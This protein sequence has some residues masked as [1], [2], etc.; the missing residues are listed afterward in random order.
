[1]GT[2]PRGLVCFPHCLRGLRGV[3]LPGDPA[4]N[5]VPR[6]VYGCAETTGP[7]RI[8][9]RPLTTTTPFLARMAAVDGVSLKGLVLGVVPRCRNQDGEPLVRKTLL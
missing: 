7:C 4:R 6:L 8:R 9:T 3:A 2:T 5:W 1:M